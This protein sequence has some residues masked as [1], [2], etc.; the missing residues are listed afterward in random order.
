[1]GLIQNEITKNLPNATHCLTW[2]RVQESHM[3]KG[4]NVVYKIEHIY[5]M[6]ILLAIGLGAAML[7]LFG[8][9]IFYKIIH[10][11]KNSTTR[12]NVRERTQAWRDTKT[13]I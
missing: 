5:G 3:K 10:Q 4:Q 2:S 9:L 13:N 11:K 8:E 12:L 1:M 7:I 6:I